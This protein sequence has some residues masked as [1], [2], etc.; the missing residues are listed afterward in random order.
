MIIKTKQQS[1]KGAITFGIAALSAIAIAS[2]GFAAWIISGGDSKDV[3]G[4]ITVETVDDNRNIIQI[5]Q[6]EGHAY[7]S[8]SKAS[9]H[10]GPTNNTG[11]PDDKSWLTVGNGKDGK[12]VVTEKLSFTVTTLVTNYTAADDTHFE[13]SLAEKDSGT[14]YS[15]AAAANYVGA[16]PSIGSGITITGEDTTDKV[17]NLDAR[18]YTITVQFSWG[19]AFGGVN[20]WSTTVE[21]ASKESF[22]SA[23]KGIVAL[24]DTNFTLTIKTT[25][26]A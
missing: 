8:G 4:N 18:K 2:T 26:T 25:K 14:K 22:I 7:T 11:S 9:I 15:D 21:D 16:L 5:T 23:L 6:I 12:A 13:V 19:T 10:F 24:N 1:K 3:S 20:P 17:N